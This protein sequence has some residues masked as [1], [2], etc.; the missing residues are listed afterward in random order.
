MLARCGSEDVITPREGLPARIS[1]AGGNSQ[2][3]TVGEPL[4]DSLIVRVSD[5]RDRPV[6]D[7][8]V[9]FELVA[10]GTGARVIPDTA[11]T[12]S[13]GQ[14][15]SRWV[16][17]QIAG[18]QR[19]EARVLGQVA[20]GT[21][22]IMFDASGAPQAPD[23]V[24][25]LSGRVQTGV[26][27]LPLSDS[28]VVIVLDSFGNPL[29]GQRIGW[30]VTGGGSVSPDS[31]STGSNGRSGARRTLGPNAGQQT[32]RAVA[33]SLPGITVVFNHTAV[34]A[35]AN[36]IVKLFGDG[37][38]GIVGLRLTD[39][40]VIR[41]R[42][43]NGNGVPGWPVTW[44]ASPGSGQVAPTQNTTDAEGE[45]FTR[46]ILGATAGV[47]TVTAT[48]Q[49]VEQQ[50]TFTAT[51]N[52]STA[53]RILAQTATT[54]AGTA[55]QPVSPTPSVKVTDANNNEVQGVTVTFRVTA[56]GGG[57]S[58]GTSSDSVATIATDAQGIATLSSW[59]LGPTAG[60]GN[61]IVQASA[62]GQSGPLS[63]RPASD[64]A[65]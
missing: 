28:L 31:T 59:T 11:I 20:A 43:A 61:N 16:L 49:G 12:G 15:T 46:W 9:A 50:V 5:S 42:D 14:A 8:Q 6:Q 30:T 36:N 51:A 45:A 40:L 62:N 65:V 52:P 37:Q 21:L 1:V 34:A 13:D 17:G 38:T 41:V 3:G 44:V 22:D 4:A 23:T 56:G 64:T 18:P 25:A 7:V 55:G 27:G 32:T 35:A 26:V 58:A 63:C 10:G 60:T 24:Y 29:A 48:T 2:S 47:M 33:D 54:L 57:V 39:S 53:T 19:V